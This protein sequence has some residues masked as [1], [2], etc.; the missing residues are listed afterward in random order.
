MSKI[1]HEKLGCDYQLI[2][3]FNMVVLPISGNQ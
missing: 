1:R 3:T 2:R